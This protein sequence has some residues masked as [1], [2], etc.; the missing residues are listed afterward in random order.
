MNKMPESI[1]LCQEYQAS[2][3][4]EIFF[5]TSHDNYERLQNNEQKA[6]TTIGK[7]ISLYSHSSDW[8]YFDYKIKS[9]AGSKI[10]LT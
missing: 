3:V 6:L 2:K 9:E 5:N 4:T 8:R 7:Q 10:G 1:K